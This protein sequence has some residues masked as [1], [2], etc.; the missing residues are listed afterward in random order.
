MQIFKHIV[1][2]VILIN[3][4]FVLFRLIASRKMEEDEAKK[5]LTKSDA[6]K[7]PQKVGLLPYKAT[8]PRYRPMAEKN[9]REDDAKEKSPS[10]GKENFSDF[11][12]SHLSESD[13][14]FLG[15]F[16]MKW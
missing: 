6:E 3:L 8:F 10:D 11:D 14:E 4:G 9:Y 12:A 1:L 2:V 15:H 7:N 13:K 5:G 16:Q